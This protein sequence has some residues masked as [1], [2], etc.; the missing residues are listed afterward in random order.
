MC[1]LVEGGGRDFREK[2]PVEFAKKKKKNLNINIA[3]CT[4]SKCKWLV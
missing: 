2:S 1:N 3:R 4:R